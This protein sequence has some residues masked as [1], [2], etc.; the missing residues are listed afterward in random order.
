METP[1]NEDW[2]VSRAGQLALEMPENEG[3]L[4]P[5]QGGSPLKT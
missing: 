5:G 4:C 3:V 2:T 1:G